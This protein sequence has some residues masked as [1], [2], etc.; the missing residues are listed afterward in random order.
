MGGTCKGL[1]QLLVLLSLFQDT[2]SIISTRIPLP[3]PVY[4][5]G[6]PSPR[7]RGYGCSRATGALTDNLPTQEKTGP[8]GRFFGMFSG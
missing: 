8:M 1:L 7:E 6:A 2:M 4:A 5:L 3:P